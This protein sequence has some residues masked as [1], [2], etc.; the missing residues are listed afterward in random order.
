MKEALIISGGSIDTEFASRY[1]KE[2]QPD[3]TIAVDSGMQF[4]YDIGRTPDIIV[5]DFDSAAPQ[6]MEYF[7]C[8]QG[9][10]IICLIPEKDDTDTEAALHRAAEAGCK[11]IHLLGATGN[12]LDHML[13]NIE[14]L[15][16]GIE[17]GIEILMADKNNRL[18]MV[19]E[20]I[21]LK[22]EEQY[23]KF[24]SLIPF[25]PE[26]KG[27]TLRGMK[28]PLTDY[29]LTCFHSLGISNEI[30]EDAGEITF[31]EGILL[32]IESKD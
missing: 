22:K 26:V 15:G 29:C 31:S 32:V 6:V 18:R 2:H 8:Q 24:V 23:G 11:K 30:I 9:I 27:V 12:R 4:F 25:T 13:G 16:I 5:G 7:K 3:I 20:G 28:Y 21:I 10:E 17:E 14:L 19:K 1:F